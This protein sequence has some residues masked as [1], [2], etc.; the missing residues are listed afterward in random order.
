LRYLRLRIGLNRNKEA[1]IYR[2]PIG[3]TAHGVI[4][5]TFATLNTL[6]AS[7]RIDR[8]VERSPCARRSDRPK[9]LRLS[10]RASVSSDRSAL[11]TMSSVCRV[12]TSR[13]EEIDLSEYRDVADVY[14][15]RGQ[16][17]DDSHNRKRIHSS[18]SYLTP[19]EF[20]R[21]WLGAKS[22]E[23]PMNRERN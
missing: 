9:Q 4:D 11:G 5:Y 18:L 23:P 14:G 12:D 20:E 15:Q 2:K 3:T 8:S 7:V 1:S 21:K 6:R 22:Y 17:L 10:L 19:A 16:L 13:A